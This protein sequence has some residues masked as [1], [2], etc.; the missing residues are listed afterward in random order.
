MLKEKG[1]EVNTV[2]KPAFQQAV[3]SVWADYESVFGKE[4]LDLV[5]KYGK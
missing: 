1:M 3:Q 4:L 5:R 2:D